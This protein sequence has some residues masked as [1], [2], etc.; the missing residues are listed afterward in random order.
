[1]HIDKI[2]AVRE[3]ESMMIA[4]IDYNLYLMRVV[5][6]DNEDPFIECK[7]DDTKV[8]IWNPY[9]GQTRS[10]ESR[11]SH[12]PNG[13]DRFS[14]ALGYEDKGSCRSYKFLRL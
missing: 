7:G 5:L 9:W 4:M 11:Y 14:Y 13:W 6:V 1:M 8:I 10:I 2:R 12:R 3:G